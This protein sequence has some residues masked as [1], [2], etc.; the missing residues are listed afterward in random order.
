MSEAS[1][2]WGAPVV[3]PRMGGCKT[4]EKGGPGISPGGLMSWV[5]FKS[6]IDDGSFEE[7]NNMIKKRGHEG[8]GRD[9]GGRGAI[10]I[11][12]MT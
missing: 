6:M 1:A 8:N 3:D 11:F 2:S 7:G 12:S 10:L 4:Y 9:G 5:V